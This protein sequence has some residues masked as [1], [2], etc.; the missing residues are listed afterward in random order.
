MFQT[1]PSKNFIG[2]T[3]D[4]MFDFRA[5]APLSIGKVL[6]GHSTVK[7]GKRI[8]TKQENTLYIAL[9]AVVGLAVAIA[10]IYF[11]H[12]YV[13]GWQITLCILLPLVGAGITAAMVNF[14][15]YF[16]GEHGIADIQIKNEN[17]ENKETVLLFKDAAYLVKGLTDRYKNGF[18]Q[19]TDYSFKWYDQGNK[20]LLEITGTYQ[21]KGGHPKY[22]N[23]YKYYWGVE[24]EKVWTN[25][26]FDKAISQIKSMGYYEFGSKY[27]DTYRLGHGFIE[28]IKSNGKSV[29]I[30]EKDIK[31]SYVEKGHLY[32]KTTTGFSW[33]N[34]N[35]I[36][37]IFNDIH[38]SKIFINL[39]FQMIQVPE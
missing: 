31:K 1:G 4:A 5:A 10:A 3:P 7:T 37:I 9:F 11:F 24:A 12:I 23:A 17:E 18:Y 13:R 6:S 8:P 38:N 30:E 21:D 20:S 29:R 22:K 15:H 32:I 14:H 25:Y 2:E 16:V 28:K 35:Q 27:G 33:F 34:E 26:I 39:Y 19:G 36:D